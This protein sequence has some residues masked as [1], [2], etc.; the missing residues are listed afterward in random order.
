M[1]I[2]QFIA[3]CEK[4]WFRVIAI[5]LKSIC[6]TLLKTLKL[7]IAYYKGIC[8]KRWKWDG[9]ISI[10][11]PMQRFIFAPLPSPRLTRG[12][13]R[14]RARARA[15]GQ[16]AEPEPEGRAKRTCLS[17]GMRW[18]GRSR[19]QIGVMQL[20]QSAPIALLLMTHQETALFSRV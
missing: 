9:M 17:S 14:A 4:R 19:G 3:D 18:D 7:R 16:R 2:R 8:E 12:E 15:R 13:A 11:V 10:K 5:L 6:K 20:L 1:R